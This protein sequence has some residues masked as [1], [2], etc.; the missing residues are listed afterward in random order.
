MWVA[1]RPVEMCLFEIMFVAFMLATM[2]RATV[3]Q[4][5]PRQDTS[6]AEIGRV[7]IT[8]KVL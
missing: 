1:G 3:S 6:R 4:T 2:D 7:S 8:E 5:A